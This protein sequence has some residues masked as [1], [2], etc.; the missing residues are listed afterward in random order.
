MLEEKNSLGEVGFTW[1]SQSGRMTEGEREEFLAQF[2][3]VHERSLAAFCVMGGIFSEGIDLK[4]ERLIGAVIIGT[5]LPQVNAE[6][7]ILREYFQEDMGNGFCY[8]YQYPGMNKV[9]QAAGRVIRTMKDKGVVA[10]LDDRFLQPEYEMLF[11][12]EWETYTVVS[13]NNVSRAL[14]DFW[15]REF[16]ACP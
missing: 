4:E 15:N 16:T 14:E 2:E 3:E 9:M 6:Q 7:E 13:L 1:I 11:P 5:G 8:A 12:R 10:L